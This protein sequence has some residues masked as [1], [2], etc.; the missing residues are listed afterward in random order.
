MG[1]W[2]GSKLLVNQVN[3]DWKIKDLRFAFLKV[4]IDSLRAEFKEFALQWVDRGQIFRVLG[5]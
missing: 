2:A 5:H 1:G 3:G 4:K